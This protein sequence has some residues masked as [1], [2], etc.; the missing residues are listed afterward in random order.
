MFFKKFTGYI[1]MLHASTSWVVEWIWVSDQ[2]GTSQVEIKITHIHHD[3][4]RKSFGSSMNIN[5]MLYLL[6]FCLPGADPD[7]WCPGKSRK[8]L[9]IWNCKRRM[10]FRPH[11]SHT[12]KVGTDYAEIF[13]GCLDA[14]SHPRHN[15]PKIKRITHH[16]IW[17]WCHVALG[18]GDGSNSGTSS[19]K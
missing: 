14:I 19:A 4:N 9:S 11:C 6:A 12:I 5:P 10:I 2:S 7:T 15:L 1:F 16:F 3:Q 13:L 8:G 17:F 18:L